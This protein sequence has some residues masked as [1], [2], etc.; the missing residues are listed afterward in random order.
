MLCTV[1]LVISGCTNT[2][3]RQPLEYLGIQQNEF[4]NK[5]V[6]CDV[7]DRGLHPVCYHLTAKTPADIQNNINIEELLK[8]DPVAIVNFDFNKSNLKPE[9]IKILQSILQDSKYQG[10]I[11]YL[12]GYTDNIG[13]ERYNNNL[14]QKRA[15]SVKYYLSSKGLPKENQVSLGFGL[16]CYVVDN[17]TD[18]NR[19]KNRR[20]EIYIDTK[21]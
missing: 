7:V 12:K 16:C 3:H 13:G 21:N 14:A 9:A 6:F 18:S 10:K 19:E 15:D 17:K 4:T 5:H 2:P 20:V 11:L 8:N 1:V